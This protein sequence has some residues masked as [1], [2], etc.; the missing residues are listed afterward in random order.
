MELYP[1]WGGYLVGDPLLDEET[2]DEEWED[3]DEDC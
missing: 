3:D 2:L 1:F